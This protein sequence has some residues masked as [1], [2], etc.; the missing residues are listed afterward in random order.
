MLNPEKIN[1]IFKNENTKKKVDLFEKANQN[2]EEQISE[3]TKFQNIEYVNENKT[4]DHENKN[5][6]NEINH[7]ILITNNNN[8]IQ[9]IKQNEQIESSQ[10]EAY[11]PVKN[12]DKV[13]LLL[14]KI[15]DYTYQN[16]SNHKQYIK[17]INTNNNQNQTNIF[18]KMINFFKCKFT[19]CNLINKLSSENNKKF[20]ILKSKNIISKVND[21]INEKNEKYIIDDKQLND[22]LNR[23]IIKT[24]NNESNQEIKKNSFIK[25]NIENI[26]KKN[27]VH[28]IRLN[29]LT[30]DKILATQNAI[31]E[32]IINDSID[33][34]INTNN[35]KN[36]SYHDTNNKILEQDIFN[37]INDLQTIKNKSNIL[38]NEN[39]LSANTNIT[40]KTNGNRFYAMIN[41][42]DTIGKSN[43]PTNTDNTSTKIPTI[44]NNIPVVSTATNIKPSNEDLTNNLTDNVIE[45]NTENKIENDDID[46][47][48]NNSNGKLMFTKKDLESVGIKFNKK[49]NIK[50]S[51]MTISQF[52][53]KKINAEE[54]VK[55]QKTSFNT[56]I[57]P[58][59]I[60]KK[61]YDKRNQHLQPIMFEEDLKIQAFQIINSNDRCIDIIRAILLKLRKTDIQ[62]ENGNSLLMYA[63]NY[64]NEKLIAILL[65]QGSDPNLKNNN[66]F[67]PVHLAASNADYDS[68]YQ[69]L[70]AGGNVNLKDKDGNTPGMYGIAS[71]DM[72][73]IKIMTDAGTDLNLKNN[74]GVNSFHFAKAIGDN[75]ILSYL[76]EKEYLVDSTV[77]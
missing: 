35:N 37:Q 50:K 9:N 54:P 4:Q 32:D 21:E 30:L 72:N 17:Q 1:D 68:L 61:V 8:N 70:F 41:P 53:A 13:K 51:G 18:Y 10:I 6:N 23:I 39:N 69:L 36:N 5:I 55:K 7:E 74:N 44:I 58:S 63:V 42:L 31:A 65:N 64:Q 15:I 19:K 76:I 56:Q 66:G 16:K 11:K 77:K 46:S 27:D 25:K 52:E 3:N 73:I 62:D 49:E 14:H 43:I 45:N 33:N 2:N 67:T 59:N 75:K 57:L 40:N 60:A 71:G 26:E 20:E 22:Y 34:K 12:N 38:I 48:F 29:S 47:K 24:N 28:E